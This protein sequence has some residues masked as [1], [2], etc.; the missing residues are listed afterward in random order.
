ML[1]PHSFCDNA[2]YPSRSRIHTPSP[3]CASPHCLS[4]SRNLFFTVHKPEVPDAPTQKESHQPKVPEALTRN[5]SKA[6]E[7]RKMLTLRPATLRVHCVAI[8]CLWSGPRGGLILEIFFPQSVNVPSK[9][10]L[11]SSVV[12][13]VIFFS[14]T[15]ITAA[16]QTKHVIHSSI[17]VRFAPV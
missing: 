4:V 15:I 2:V 14:D 16:V 11:Q 9:N 3:M 17:C 6:L 7:H 12:H 10:V 8:R 13:H 1:R 5:E